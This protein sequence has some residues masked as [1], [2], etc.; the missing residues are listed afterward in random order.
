MSLIDFIPGSKT[1]KVSQGP[2]WGAAAISTATH[3]SATSVN[4]PP[5]VGF[6]DI[7]NME[8]KKKKE[9]K[10][11]IDRNRHHTKWYQRDEDTKQESLEAIMRAEKEERDNL[12]VARRLQEEENKAKERTKRERSRRNS[13]KK[14]HHGSKASGKKQCSQKNG[15]KGSGESR[16]RA[17]RRKQST[18]QR[19]AKETVAGWHYPK[20][21]GI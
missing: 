13:G 11:T 7:M 17:S 12:E 19:D 5:K 3:S 2:A 15:T 14:A 16:T 20:H 18:G 10:Y 4:S 6:M 21:M 8:A 1:Q 9:E